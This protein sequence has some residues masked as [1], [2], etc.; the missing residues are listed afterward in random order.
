MCTVS[1]LYRD[2]GYDVL[3]NR[4]EK[5]TRGSAIAPQIRESGDSRFAAPVDSDHGGSWLSVNEHGLTLCLLNAGPAIA[6]RLIGARSRGLVLM[7]VAGC[8]SADEVQKQIDPSNTLPFTLAVFD[9]CH[10]TALFR[11]NGSELARQDQSRQT[12]LLVSSSFDPE[13]VSARRTAEFRRQVQPAP[14]LAGL[15]NFHCS[16]GDGPSAYSTCMHRADARTVSFSWVRV[17]PA[18]A[19]LFYAPDSPCRWPTGTSVELSRL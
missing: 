6:K 16:H 15:H 5:K 7:D 17:D 13:R 10:S 4:D 2:G 9:P 3:C 12:G 18:R 11:W 14:T 8:S 19:S 1:W